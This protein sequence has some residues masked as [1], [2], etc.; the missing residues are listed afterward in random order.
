MGRSLDARR[1]S[2]ALLLGL[3]PGAPV[4]SARA[5]GVPRERRRRASGASSSSST[6]SST[7]SS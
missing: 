7:G 4:S 6:A 2:A 3:W 1:S 5:Q